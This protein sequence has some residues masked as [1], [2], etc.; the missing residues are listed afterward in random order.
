MCW[1]RVMPIGLEPCVQL[2]KP[3]A[4]RE[5]KPDESDQS[6]DEYDW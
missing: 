5:S 3:N 2:M 1:G 6:L 4:A